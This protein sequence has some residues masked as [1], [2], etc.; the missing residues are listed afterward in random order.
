MI[1]D[2]DFRTLMD[3]NMIDDKEIG[4]IRVK[5]SQE[6]IL[7]LLG[8][9][10]EAFKISGAPLLRFIYFPDLTSHRSASIDLGIIVPGKGDCGYLVGMD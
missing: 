7:N 6:S 2:F 10:E 8:E 4:R 3:L 9:D 1:D 5:A